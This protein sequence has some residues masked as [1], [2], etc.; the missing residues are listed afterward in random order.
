MLKKKSKVWSIGL[1]TDKG[2]VKPV[3][4]D[5]MFIR[6]LKDPDG[7]ELLL[8]MV[9]DGMGGYQYGDLASQTIVDFFDKWVKTHQDKLF[10]AM[11]PFI[12]FEQKWPEALL[13]LNEK[14]I[15]YGS[16]YQKKLGSTL[17]ILALYKGQYMIAHIGDSRIYQWEKLTPYRFNQTDR[18]Y[19]TEV[20]TESLEKEQTLSQLTDDHSWVHMQVKQG[21]LSRQEAE[22]H[23]KRH[24]LLQ[25]LGIEQKLNPSFS[26]GSYQANDQFIVCSDGFHTIY[27]EEQLLKI[28][29]NNKREKIDLQ[30]KVEQLIDEVI[31][32]GATDNITLL[33][34]EPLTLVN[35]SNWK[36]KFFNLFS[37][38]R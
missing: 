22:V 3:N 38:R 18:L 1:A 30:T 23:P 25:C 7:A 34:I 19:E 16:F 5:R 35:P 13:A 9:A 17:S 15:D 26:Y 14:L 31:Q 32:M 2:P 6:L 27:P 21:K 4:E 29:Q 36:R 10:Q 11:H 28:L 37:F 8:T 12:I 24:V 33:M 20:E